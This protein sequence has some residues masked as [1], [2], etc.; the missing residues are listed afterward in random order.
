MTRVLIAGAVVLA[1]VGAT[2]ASGQAA[3]DPVAS[4]KAVMQSVAGAAGLSGAMLKGEMAYSPAAGKAAIATFNAAGVVFGDYFPE[5]SDTGDTSAAPKIW[6]DRAG[7]EAEVAKLAAAAS[8][9]MQASGR[10]GP[11]DLESFKAVVGP[12]LA[13][14]RSCHQGFRKR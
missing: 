3:E 4:R 13:T 10:E 12:V 5:G 9:A 6:E 1:L 11:A 14:C 8:A 7:F 2:A